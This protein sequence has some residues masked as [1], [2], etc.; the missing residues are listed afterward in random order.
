MDVFAI[1]EAAAL[2][3]LS[4]PRVTCAD[5][6][7]TSC[8]RANKDTVAFD[9]HRHDVK[10]ERQ[11]YFRLFG[12]NMAACGGCN[13]QSDQSPDIRAGINLRWR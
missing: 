11:T 12:K 4:P 2:S 3:A 9:R 13:L 1:L 8:S 7:V 10:K 6:G 5:A